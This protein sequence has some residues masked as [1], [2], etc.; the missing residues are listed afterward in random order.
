MTL[1]YKLLT[2]LLVILILISMFVI[3]ASLNTIAY[4]NQ[5]GKNWFNIIKTTDYLE[6]YEGAE[7]FKANK[8]EVVFRCPPNTYYS[9]N[10]QSKQ[11]TLIHRLGK[12][13][14]FR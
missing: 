3:P 8:T 5:S 13:F 11:V 6:Q 9:I 10:K 1:K 2:L 7:F 14:Y 12:D 4:N